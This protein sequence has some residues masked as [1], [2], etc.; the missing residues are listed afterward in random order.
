MGLAV[1][2]D[3]QPAKNRQDD[4]QNTLGESGTRHDARPGSHPPPSGTER[5]KQ[6][7][8]KIQS[9]HRWRIVR[10]VPLRKGSVPLQSADACPQAG[11]LGYLG[12]AVSPL[13]GV[14]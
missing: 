4:D 2:A 12:G 10:P 13:H 9:A 11:A 7:D 5:P 8:L 6:S 3:L 14:N 1:E